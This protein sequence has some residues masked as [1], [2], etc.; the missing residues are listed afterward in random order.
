M[1]S[2]HRR[3]DKSF[4]SKRNFRFNLYEND[5][6]DRINQIV[7]DDDYGNLA[8]QRQQFGNTVEKTS[9]LIEAN[10]RRHDAVIF[11]DKTLEGTQNKQKT[12]RNFYSL[13]IE[14]LDQQK[15]ELWDSFKQSSKYST[16]SLAGPILLEDVETKRTRWKNQ[17]RN[18]WIQRYQPKTNE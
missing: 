4:N 8:A 2:K 7:D 10:D 1:S 15:N 18:L 12:R 5:R 11:G 3:G 6:Q 16:T 14:I 13:F 9:R 17:I